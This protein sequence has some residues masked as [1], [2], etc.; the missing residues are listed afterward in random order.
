MILN[1]LR[2]RLFYDGCKVNEF[3]ALALNNLG[4]IL[5]WFAIHCNTL[6]SVRLHES[7]LFK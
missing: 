1:L 6:E 2:E 5:L 4:V 3:V 7:S